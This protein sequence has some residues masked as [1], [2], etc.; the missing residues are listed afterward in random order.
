MLLNQ[1]RHND[2]YGVNSNNGTLLIIQ[3]MHLQSNVTIV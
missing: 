3:D 1:R 2:H